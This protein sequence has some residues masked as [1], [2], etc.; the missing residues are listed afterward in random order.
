MEPELC[1]SLNLM[2]LELLASYLEVKP[3][4]IDKLYQEL[5]ADREFLNEL[6]EQIKKARKLFQKGVFRHDELDSVDW[7]SIQRIMLYILVRLY[8]PAVCLET[9]VFYGGNTSFILNALRR[10]KEGEL[11]SIDLP[12]NAIAKESRKVC[13]SASFFSHLAISFVYRSKSVWKRSR[14]FC[15]GFVLGKKRLLNT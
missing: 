5:L 9:G 4:A 3:E 15:A 11:I 14:N 7:M 2:S 6:N 8:K 1:R 13:L 10:N 12:G